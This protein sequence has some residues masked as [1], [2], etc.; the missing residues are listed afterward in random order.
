M[1]K[2]RDGDWYVLKEKTTKPFERVKADASRGLL[3][4]LSAFFTTHEWRGHS[5]H[6]SSLGAEGILTYEPGTITIRIRI[7]SFLGSL[8]LSKILSDVEV[9]T[10]DVSGVPWAANKDVFIVH[11]HGELAMVQLKELL[12]SLGLNPIVLMDQD[13]HGMTIIEKFEYYARTCSFAFI[14]M[15]PDDRT[16]GVS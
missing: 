10:L 16:V 1:L 3:T 8:I 15:T 13:D 5:C 12:A 11:G 9:T 6:I 14:L 4:G 2:F 7:T